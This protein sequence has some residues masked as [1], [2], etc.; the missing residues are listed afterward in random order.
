[1][2]KNVRSIKDP[3]KD[4]SPKK[5]EGE[6]AAALWLQSHSVLSSF[7]VVLMSCKVNFH[8]V[9]SALAYS[10][11]RIQYVFFVHNPFRI[12]DPNHRSAPSQVSKMTAAK[13]QIV[14]GAYWTFFLL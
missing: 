11:C 9:R 6:T 10:A 14:E 3:H 12:T 8:V 5:P 13:F 4:L 2:P 7:G 1:M